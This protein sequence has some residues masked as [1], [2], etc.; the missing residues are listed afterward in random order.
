V[1]IS[2]YLICTLV[3]KVEA[4]SRRWKDGLAK[5]RCSSEE[6]Q[7]AVERWKTGWHLAMPLRLK[8]P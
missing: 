8:P 1:C 4:A 5:S 2:R 3:S 6:G 7:E